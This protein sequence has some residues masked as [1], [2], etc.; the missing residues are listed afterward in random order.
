MTVTDIFSTNTNERKFQLGAGI[1][2]NLTIDTL[3]KDIIWV[4]LNAIPFD[5]FVVDAMDDLQEHETVL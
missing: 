1:D 2:G 4:L 5:D 3:L